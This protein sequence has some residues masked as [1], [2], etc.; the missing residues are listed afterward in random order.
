MAE[1]R[2]GRIKFIWKGAWSPSTAY[3]KDDVVRVNG[4]VF[5][6]TISHTSDP[7]FNIDAD[8]VPP[9]W[10]LMGDGQSWRGDWDNNVI[11]YVN[12]LVKYGG[13]VYLC[14]IG[15]TSAATDTLGLEV[16]YV[17]AGQDST[18]SKWDLFAESFDWQGAWQPNY[19]YKT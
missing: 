15:H 16:D 11:Y 14:L 3:V 6:C 5:V 9:K 2:L 7:D 17:K 12:D 10:N 18:L 8:F 13:N 1:F 4:K 19:R